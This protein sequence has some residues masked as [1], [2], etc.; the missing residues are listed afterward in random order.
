MMKR[1]YLG[2]L[3]GVAALTGCTNGTPS[4][5]TKSPS[6]SS[7]T[8]TPS[9]PAPSFSLAWSEY[10]SWSVFGVA[11]KVGLIDK[12]QGKLGSI[13]K[14]WNVDIVLNQAEYDP[15]LSQ[16]GANQADA[17]CIT[18]MDI[19]APSLKRA[20]VAILPTSTSVGA[21]ACITVGIKDIDGLKGKTT[22]GLE[23]SVSQYAF[24]RLLELKGKKPN[25][26]PFK[27][28]DP[29]VA[30]SGMQNSQPEFQSI[31]V[32]NPFVM[33]T[34]RTRKESSV[35]FDSADIPEEIIDMVVVGK[36][37][38][39][40][41]GGKRFAYAIVD[42]YYEVNKR[43]ADPKTQDETLI[44]LGE[45]FSKL[46]LEDMKKVVQQTRFYDTAEK[47]LGLFAGDTFQ[48]KTMPMVADFCVKHEMVEGQPSVGF[49]DESKQL[50]FDLQFLKGIKDGISPDQV[51]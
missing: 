49:G 42:A 33:Q 43:I 46:G 10:P 25:E 16:Y 27:N 38:L 8:A 19:L 17:V 6:G 22:W 21:D 40:K 32:W 18:N 7:T 26:F 51:K 14:K 47:A 24:E 3:I 29:G 50:N 12:D 23:K 41:P 30:A 44:A 37:S 11:N 20:S 48:S 34:L 4:N 35:L 13:E 2:L 31:M 1:T 28:Q 36:E 39:N 45:D 15:C 5:A 9:G